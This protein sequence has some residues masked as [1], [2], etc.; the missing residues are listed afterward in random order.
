MTARILGTVT[1]CVGCP[2]RQYYSAGVYECTAVE[3]A[4]DV[5]EAMPQWC[6]LPEYP[7]IAEIRAQARAEMVAEM[8]PVAEV[9]HYTNGSYQRNYR[10]RWLRDVDAGTRLAIIPKD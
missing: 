3:R 1:R 7:T 5:S 4:L 8:V 2:N 6:P 9:T 10:L